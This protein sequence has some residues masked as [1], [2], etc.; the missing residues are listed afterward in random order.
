[1]TLVLHR[2]ATE[3]D[4]AGLRE[5]ETPE[6]TSS[7][8]PIPHFRVVDLVKHS[9]TYYG[10]T[11]TEEHFG[12]TEDG[13]RFFGLL[14]LRSEYGQYT[15]TLG[16]RNSNDKSFLVGIAFGSRTFVC[17]NLAFI[18]E[19]TIKRKHTAKLKFELPGLI[20]NIVEPL[21]ERRQEQRLVF[22]RYQRT[23]L[24]QHQADNAIM[25]LWRDDVIGVQRIADV[26]KQ[27][28]EPDFE[29]GGPTA[30]RLFNAA[31]FALTGRV[32]ENPAI[33][34]KLHAVIDGVCE[35]V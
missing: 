34:R 23:P 27:W 25:Q 33:T 1:M 26:H 28:Q 17:D 31:T 8:V 32:A 29:W 3:I 10:H 24:L 13:A 35:T 11:I 18:G 7:H 19:H 2:G 21:A 4:F 9:L 14:T 20:A 12:V 5:L 22:E 6:P 30:Y 16:L 15:D